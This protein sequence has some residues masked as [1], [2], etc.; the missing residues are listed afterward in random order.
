MLSNWAIVYY[1]NVTEGSLLILVNSIAVITILSSKKLRRPFGNILLALLF[2]AHVICGILSVFFGIMEIGYRGHTMISTGLIIRDFFAGYEVIFT[3]SMSVE[4]FVAVNNPMFYDLLS[5][6]HA[7]AFVVV[8]SSLPV[9][10][11]TWRVLSNAAFVAVFVVTFIGSVII[12]I[13]N[14]YLYRSIKRHCHDISS[15]VVAN[16]QVE[17]LEKKLLI[18]KRKMKGLR[19]CVLISAT[20]TICWVPIGLKFFIK[21]ML[22]IEKRAYWDAIFTFVAYFNGF[23]DVLIFFYIKKTARLQL[24]SLFYCKK[25]TDGSTVQPFTIQF[26]AAE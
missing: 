14:M 19:T 22:G 25:N 7:I 8:V 3:I 4:R 21:F 15:K 6:K 17:E 2:I 16:S 26:T 18:E 23:Q 13:C 5:K 1:A 20:Y 12:T 24:K 10:F 11:V 9:V